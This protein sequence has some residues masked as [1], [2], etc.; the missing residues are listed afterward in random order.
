MGATI[1]DG[2]AGRRGTGF[3][4]PT[5][6]IRKWKREVSGP[7]IK[8]SSQKISAPVAQ[9]SS[10]CC[11]YWSPNQSLRRN[12]AEVCGFSESTGG[13]TRSWNRHL[14]SQ[15]YGCKCRVRSMQR[16]IPYTDVIIDPMNDPQV[17]HWAKDLQ[18]QSYELRAAIKLV[19]PRLSHLRRYYGNLRTSSSWRTG[20]PIRRP[21]IGQPLGRRF[22]RFGGSTKTC[23]RLKP[24][25]SSPQPRLLIKRV[26]VPSFDTV[27]LFATP[28]A[29][30]KKAGE[31]SRTGCY[32]NLH[33]YA[34][35]TELPF[36]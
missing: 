28:E 5:L 33:H 22:F 29:A 16:P 15:L 1:I 17:Q 24:T 26:T 20:G 18:V 3:A 36:L 6:E 25:A 11:G 32:E 23:R 12:G 27:R 13:A 2:T 7:Q 31:M 35:R 4:L 9:R 30:L 21:G 19:G 34:R 14:A 8:F 10:I